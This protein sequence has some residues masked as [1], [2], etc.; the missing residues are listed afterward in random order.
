MV[1]VTLLRNDSVQNNRKHSVL[2]TKRV[3]QTVVQS[4][5]LSN[6]YWNIVGIT[7]NTGSEVASRMLTIAV[8]TG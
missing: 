7:A 1:V 3:C 2:N 6:H 8:T 5:A 4:K